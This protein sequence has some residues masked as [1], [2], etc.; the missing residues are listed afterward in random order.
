MGAERGNKNL[1]LSQGHAVASPRIARLRP[2]TFVPGPS[3][4][5][6]ASFCEFSIDFVLLKTSLDLYSNIR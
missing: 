1:P 4:A 3:L 6:H 2:L 5:V